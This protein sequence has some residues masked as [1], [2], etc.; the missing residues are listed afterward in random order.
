MRSQF[1]YEEEDAERAEPAAAALPKLTRGALTGVVM[2]AGIFVY[3]LMQGDIPVLLLTLAF[4]L[5]MLRPFAAFLAGRRGA[6]LSNMLK[7]LSLTLFAGAVLL[8]FL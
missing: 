2:A 5:F 1:M 3:G 7:G 4:L 8:A 6:S